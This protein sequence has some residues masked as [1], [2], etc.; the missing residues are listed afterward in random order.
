MRSWLRWWR[1][2][3]SASATQGTE[4]RQYGPAVDIKD[5]LRFGYDWRAY[6]INAAAEL[7]ADW[8]DPYWRKDGYDIRA[9]AYRRDNC[10]PTTMNDPRWP[11][12]GRERR[13]TPADLAGDD[14]ARVADSWTLTNR[15]RLLVLDSDEILQHCYLD[16]EGHEHWQNVPRVKV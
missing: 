16:G 6:A 12:R 9:A 2:T 4:R 3:S 14:P 1:K 5:D 10:D 13:L 8:K 15:I 7:K 11:D